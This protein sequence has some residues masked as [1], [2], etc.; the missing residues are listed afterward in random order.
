MSTMATHTPA[1]LIKDY[2]VAGGRA[3]LFTGW[4][5]KFGKLPGSPDQVITLIDQGNSANFPHLLVDWV[6]LQIIVR[7]ERADNGYQSSWLMVQQLRD[8]LL[9][10]DGHPAEFTELD[11]IVERSYP[12]P[13]GYDDNDR[14]LWSWNAK[15][16][17]EPET[18]ALTHRVSL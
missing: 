10:L 3:S 18:N 15:L 5:F 9:G 17:V 2:L 13:L 8:I 6:G 14:H 4:A 11:G 7:S 12:V 1:M 16:L